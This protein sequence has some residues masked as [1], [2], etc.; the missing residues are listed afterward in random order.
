MQLF[1]NVSNGDLYNFI[2]SPA[3]PISY[4]IFST[5]LLEG[6]FCFFLFD[7]LK[8]HDGLRGEDSMLSVLCF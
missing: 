2:S 1:I 4:S 6:N 8:V 3:I 5:V 7:I